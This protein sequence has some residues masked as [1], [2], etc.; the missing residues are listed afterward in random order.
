MILIKMEAFIVKGLVQHFWIQVSLI[1]RK[2]AFSPFKMI[3][4][5][6]LKFLNNMGMYFLS[7]INFLH[8]YLITKS[9]SVS[10]PIALR[11]T[12]IYK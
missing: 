8:H 4:S 12:M 1:I 5:F 10:L 7:L 9:V 2:H 3:S 6:K 11:I